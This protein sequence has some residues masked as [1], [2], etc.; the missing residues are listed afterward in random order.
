MNHCSFL[1][2]LERVA[3]ESVQILYKTGK[4]REWQTFQM[5]SEDDWTK[6]NQS[7]WICRTNSGSGVERLKQTVSFDSVVYR[8]HSD[9]K[10]VLNEIIA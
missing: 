1:M 7:G 6:I 3:N 9:S 10:E 4:P 8:N 2:E 5:E